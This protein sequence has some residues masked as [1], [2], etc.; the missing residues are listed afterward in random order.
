MASFTIGVF[1]ENPLLRDEACKKLGKKTSPDDVTF[2]SGVFEGNIITALDPAAF[3]AKVQPLVFSA[4]L[5]DYCVVIADGVSPRLGEIIVTLDL[6]GKKSGC[7]VSQTIDFTPFVKGTSL[8]KWPVFA[9]FDE[10]KLDALK[11]VPPETSGTPKG[12]V[13]HAFEV[14]GVGTIVLGVLKRGEISVHDK[15]TVFPILK[16]IEV[17]SIQMHDE[18]VKKA[19]CNDRFGLSV[20]GLESKDFERGFVLG[21]EMQSS[22]KVSFELAPS[23]FLREPVNNGE[24]LHASAGFQMAPCK[25]SFEGSE[26]KAG[27]KKQAVVEFEK[28]FAFDSE[29]SLVLCRLNSR[30][31]RV[32][33]SGKALKTA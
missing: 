8:E 21:K 25:I 15:L 20:R 10:A 33:A 18:D 12:I 24:V 16:Q 11:F 5:S 14:K 32:V 28:E 31:L 22:K 9:T 30:T 23:R 6:L 27:E 13:D 7:L 17:R 1:A 29:D 4:N 3:P 19:G 2:Y 26:A